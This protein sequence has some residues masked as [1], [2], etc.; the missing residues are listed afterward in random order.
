MNENLEGYYSFLLPPE[1][2]QESL[3][4][5]ES[6]YQALHSARDQNALE[7]NS[8]VTSISKAKITFS[9]EN[10]SKHKEVTAFQPGRSF[11][12]HRI[13]RAAPAPAGEFLSLRRFQN[14][15][16]LVSV[17]PGGVLLVP[18]SKSMSGAVVLETDD[19]VR[20]TVNRGSVFFP[21]VQGGNKRV[22]LVR[23]VR[24]QMTTVTMTFSAGSD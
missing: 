7:T 2:L 11:R 23:F 4:D 22:D 21:L 17:L 15:E 24:G 20:S 3:E 5:G 12:L 13:G 1:A 16:A 14:I 9:K 19:G 8:K 18:V 6:D 10:A